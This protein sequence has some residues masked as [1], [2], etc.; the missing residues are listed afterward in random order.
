[1]GVNSQ[2]VQVEI[3]GIDQLVRELDAIAG[4]D[5]RKSINTL[6]KSLTKEAAKDIVLPAARNL[7]P[8]DTSFLESR[9]KVKPIGRS[10]KKVG[11]TVG[12]TDPLFTGATFYGG[13]HEFGWTDKRGTHPPD[14]YLRRA[15]YPNA[16]AIKQRYTSGLRKW[17]KLRNSLAVAG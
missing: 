7:A 1:M 14:S 9:I 15:L 3:E 2:A 8:N 4:Q 13:F 5:G 17:L 11:Y 12:F 10:R 6:M 16:A